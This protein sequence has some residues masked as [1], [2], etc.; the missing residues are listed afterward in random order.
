MDPA[1]GL[2]F[3]AKKVLLDP[4]GRALAVP[5]VYDRKAAADPGD[6]APRAMKSVVASLHGYDWEG[7]APLRHPYAQ[8]VIDQIRVVP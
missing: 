3:D 5:S 8:T 2:R 6:N 1:R 7:D 4:Y